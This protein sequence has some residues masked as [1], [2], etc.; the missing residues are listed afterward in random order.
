MTVFVGAIVIAAFIYLSGRISSLEREVRVL[1]GGNQVGSIEKTHQA[2]NN[3]SRKDINEDLPYEEQLNAIDEKD[4]APFKAQK[5]DVK[6]STIENEDSTEFKLGSKFFTIIGAVA[7]I[8]GVGFFVRYAFANDLISE[9]TRIFLGLLAGLISLGI[10]W[11]ARKKYKV[12]GEILSGTG[13]GLWY[14]SLFGAHSLYGL[15][16][17]QT[18]FLLMSLVTLFGIFLSLKY[19]SKYLA[20]FTQ[21]GGFL[22][23]FWVSG[24]EFTGILFTYTLLLTLS[25][26][27][28]TV[29]ENWP[30]LRIGNFI[31]VV[32]VFLMWSS[33]NASNIDFP[34][35]L[36]WY[37][38]LFFVVF[39]T[40]V[41]VNYFAR[42]NPNT[43]IA[44]II[45]IAAPVLYYFAN[46][47]YINELYSDGLLTLTIALGALYTILGLW[48]IGI[49]ND[50]KAKIFSTIFLSVAFIFFSIAV[51][52]HFEDNAMAVAWLVLGL[53]GIISSFAIN[54]PSLRVFGLA[55]LA[56]GVGRTIAFDLDLSEDANP[57]MNSRMLTFLMSAAITSIASVVYSREK[58][59]LEKTGVA[60]TESQKDEFTIVGN[61][62]IATSFLLPVFIISLE[63]MHF[64]KN[65]WLVIAWAVS[66]LLA[67][68][69][70]L[71][72]KEGYV[73][74]VMSLVLFI[75]ASIR[76]AF[77][78]GSVALL[79]HVPIMNFRFFSTAVL[80]SS[81]IAAALY[82][83]K[84]KEKISEHEQ[85][86]IA[87]FIFIV[88]NA[89]LLWL[90]SVEIYDFFG[91]EIAV[92]SEK[93]S[94]RMQTL[95]NMQRAGLSVGWAI[96]A[97]L[98]LMVGI[99]KK[100]KLARSISI[101]LF[102]VVIIKVFLYDTTSLG[103]LYRFVS[104]ITLGIVLLITGYL[105]Y[106]FKDRIAQFIKAEE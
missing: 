44:V 79:E 29:K 72:L 75:F 32:L 42:K 64:Y 88:V 84:R 16:T 48:F 41:L 101:G 46:S 61:T 23:P 78:D 96:Y 99:A 47:F 18:A 21:V 103:D 26:M 51:P 57:W 80:V 6:P 83:Y 53:V 50:N 40:S 59:K 8:A 2:L 81:L 17:A 97:I 63:I 90:L 91:K 43:S 4:E 94:E 28:V 100:S 38:T 58:N 98:L 27:A 89:L 30:N 66:A 65:G 49:P 22:T 62:L 20:Y 45:T 82:L 15:I 11:F 14:L 19:Q 24:F 9:T 33:E 86:S 54:V 92:M 102:L 71:E 69:I 25:V 10:G 31:G 3:Q 36:F 70:S 37:S 1:K 39:L 7:V 106:R 93:N 55:L 34:K 5:T 104:F 52:L 74:R 85:N 35:N 73:L 67:L 77:F 87:G 95:R 68:G 13:L 76:L 12:Y 56:L 105:Y 60:L